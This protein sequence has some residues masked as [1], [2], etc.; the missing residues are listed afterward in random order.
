MNCEKQG[1]PFYRVS[2]IDGA[3]EE[4]HFKS[5]EEFLASILKL[6]KAE[7]K[8]TDSETKRPF[9]PFL[10]DVNMTGL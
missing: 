10:T 5:V 8:S 3:V 6:S 2:L 4:V 7:S 1:G 9:A